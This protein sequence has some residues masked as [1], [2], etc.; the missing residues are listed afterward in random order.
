MAAAGA[1]TAGMTFG[2]PLPRRG[3]RLRGDGSVVTE[4]KRQAQTAEER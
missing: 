4:F 1:R 2:L 3:A